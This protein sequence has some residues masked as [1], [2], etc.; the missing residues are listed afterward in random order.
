[1]RGE[2]GNES[3]LEWARA[4]KRHRVKSPRL[5]ASHSLENP[6]PP[7]ACPLLHTAHSSGGG[8]KRRRIGTEAGMD[9]SWSMEVLG[10]IGRWRGR[11]G[12]I[13][14][15]MSG[16]KAG[17]CQGF[18][19]SSLLFSFSFV[20]WLGDTISFPR[21]PPATH[22]FWSLTVFLRL[23]GWMDGRGMNSDQR[24]NQT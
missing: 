4:R 8:P 6:R 7:E 15:W 20:T 22:F 9:N 14:R 23:D 2:G 12:G 13:E 10:K 1:M 16:L 17:R 19:H 11:K 5:S 21:N 18:F 24:S 3:E